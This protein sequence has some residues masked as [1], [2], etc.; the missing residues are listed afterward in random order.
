MLPFHPMQRD[1]QIV[2][3]VPRGR[4]GWELSE[5]PMP[6]S[7]LH[8]EVV[9]LLKAILA[10]WASRREDTLVARGFAIRWDEEQPRI[11]L[12]PDVC[13]FSPAPPRSAED[14]DLRSV[15]TWMPG[16]SPPILAIEVVSDTNPHKDYVIA[17]DK[18]A[19]SGTRELWVF[20]PKLVGPNSH[21]G[22]FRLQIWQRDEQGRFARSYE[23]D[24][25]GYSE[26]LRAHVV[27]VEEGRKLRIADD[28]DG[29]QL[30]MTSAESERVA[31][32]EALARVA[33]LEAALGKK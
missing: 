5:E 26:L 11:G 8:D 14:H 7:L 32:E 30:W 22:P 16:H 6:E 19:S 31:K 25:P 15:R 17:P 9:E 4:R 24:G 33:E 2:Y 10:H 23:G 18:Y 28:R 21:G 12:D 27:T 3:G 13:V 29:V 20:D 1:A